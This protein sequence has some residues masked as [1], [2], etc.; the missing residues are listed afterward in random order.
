MSDD[1]PGPEQIGQTQP[2]ALQPTGPPAPP[3]LASD[4]AQLNE[5]ALRFFH[6]RLADSWA[7]HQLE[8]RGFG[9][10]IQQRWQAGYAPAEWDALTSYLRALG[11]PDPLIEAAGLARRS[12]R[13]T[14]TRVS[15]LK[16][17]TTD[18]QRHVQ[19]V[20]SA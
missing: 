6:S 4:V 18:T 10:A 8:R 19:S 13:R 1:Q 16:A 15:N 11:F 12:Q 14:S 17:G 9:S 5:I 7:P 2:L 3:G 20:T